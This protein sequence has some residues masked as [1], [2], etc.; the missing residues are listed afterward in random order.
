MWQNK[1]FHLTSNVIISKNWAIRLQGLIV[2]HA[3]SLTELKFHYNQGIKLANHGNSP[4]AS[5]F[6]VCITGCT[7]WFVQ[8][9]FC[10]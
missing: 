1:M 8:S 9:C 5:T 7:E 4:I 6:I 2:Q 3:S 10:Q